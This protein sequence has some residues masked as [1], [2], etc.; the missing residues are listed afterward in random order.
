LISKSIVKI[1]VKLMHFIVLKQ[2]KLNKN[3]NK[4]NNVLIKAFNYFYNKFEKRN[5]DIVALIF[6]EIIELS[7]E[8]L[9]QVIYC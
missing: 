7:F 2:N 4:A 6:V 5:L 9:K 1:V 3:K 8:I